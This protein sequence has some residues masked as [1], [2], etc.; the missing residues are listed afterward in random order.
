MKTILTIAQQNEFMK[1]NYQL[2]SI[3]HKWSCRGYGNSRLVD[4]HGYQMNK[5]G[6]CGYDRFGAVL[7]DFITDTFSNELHKLAK[8]ECKGARMS[9]RKVSGKF[10]GLFYDAQQKRAYVDGACGSNCM[11]KILNAIGFELNYVNETSGS[12]TGSQFYELAPVSK[13]NRKYL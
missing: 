9:R 5:R 7:G 4:L 2:S 11:Q 6:G 1:S 10:Y 13:H 12:V 3:E 8:R